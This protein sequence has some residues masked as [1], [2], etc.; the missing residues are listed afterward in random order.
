MATKPST[1]PA[2]A[3]DVTN[4]D[5]PSAGQ[6]ATGWTP[7]QTGVSDYDNWW[8]KLAYDWIEYLDD[9]AF[10]GNHSV[11][12]ELVVRGGPLYT[13]PLN[14]S[15]PVE[16]IARDFR[17]RYRWG[18]DRYGYPTGQISQWI[19]EW[20]T[21]GTTEPE[22]WTWTTASAQHTR[23]YS[24]PLSTMPTRSVAV[25]VSGATA[26]GSVASLVAN[27]TAYITNDSVTVLEFDVDVAT[28]TAT[29]AAW[30]IG[31]QFSH[32]GAWD[33]FIG[34]VADTSLTSWYLQTTGSA[35][36]TN[37]NT[38][39]VIN[40]GLDRIRL[41]IR[42]SSYTGLAAGTSEVKCYI[43]GTLVAT[44]TH[45]SPNTE[46][47]RPAIL[48]SNAPT[49]ANTTNIRV[50]RMRLTWNHRLTQDNL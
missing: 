47:V 37:T 1:T 35:G 14:D 22:G 39:V 25:Q 19:E 11:T 27:P 4:N 17:E 30:K 13:T 40:A 33:Y 6:K 8:K 50:G 2:W 48:T 15:T 45:I 49:T 3:T 46:A 5:E 41:E 42:G 16:I 31:L 28:F 32:A 24:D 44:T 18:V 10:T 21:A 20:R 23:A 43:N 7:G 36:T 38:G 9:G 12:G 34:L 26:G 29:N